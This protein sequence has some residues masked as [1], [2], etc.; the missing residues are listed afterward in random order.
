[1]DSRSALLRRASTFLSGTLVCRLTGMLRDILM[2][3]AFGATGSVAAFMVGFRFSHLLRR[4]LGE[5][6]MQAAF[7]PKFIE[8]KQRE[9]IAALQFFRSL[10]ASVSLLLFALIVIAELFFYF[11]SGET[12]LLTMLMLPGLFF[13][14]LSGI[15]S[16]F[17]QCE[18]RYFLAGAAPVAFNV[19]WIV[20]ILAL[21]K[22]S[23]E[24]AMPW[25]AAAVSL[26]CF[27]QWFVATFQVSK[28][29]SYASWTFQESYS[30]RKE[31]IKA[32]SLGIIGV[33]STQINSA[34]DSL[35]ATFS[36]Q[37]G[38]VYLWYALRIEQLPLGLFALALSGALLPTLSRTIKSKDL[39]K[40]RLYLSFALNQASLL[41]LP[42]TFGLFAAGGS[43][44]NLLF[45]HGDFSEF[46]VNETKLCLWGYAAGLPAAT[47]VTLYG[48]GFYAVG[49]Y[50]TPTYGVVAT[51]LIGVFLNYIAI[52]WLGLGPVAIAITTS[53]SAWINAIFLHSR[54]KR[55]IGPFMNRDNW[56]GI[57]KAVAACI[58]AATAAMYIDGL[59]Y[60]RDFFIQFSACAERGVV[61]VL[62]C[63]LCYLLFRVDLM[64][65][66]Q[67]VG[68]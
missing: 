52:W 7:I 65:D 47:L 59:P 63:A 32:L 6:A 5:G 10:K 15:N 17:L 60:S 25:L 41:I 31:L 2:A 43:I 26:A 11:L 13:I 57:G 1:M 8:I 49:D 54:L 3:W 34:I 22:L 67:E 14:C 55:R 21:C 42:C 23:V 30:D 48:P 62:T 19:V 50:R 16:A 56:V 36:S 66:T 33:S 27:A 20:A 58:V 53:I 40:S 64:R 61:Y 12:A 28:L 4:I 45:G 68:S 37:A 29:S 24:E 18:G 46:D 35:F 39:V 44:A 51:V 9:P 38:P